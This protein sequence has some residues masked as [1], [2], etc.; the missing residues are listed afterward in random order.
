MAMSN[1]HKYLYKLD[2]FFA[3]F[4]WEH[5]VL[6]YL[7][8]RLALIEVKVHFD[9]LDCWLIHEHYFG[10]NLIQERFLFTG[11]HDH[12]LDVFQYF[13]NWFAQNFIP[14]K[15]FIIIFLNIIRFELWLN[16]YYE[17]FFFLQ[18]H[19]EVMEFPI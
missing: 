7:I 12:F 14:S 2:L 3:D 18:G 4:C 9:Q 1:F 10:F 6:I 19:S 17:Y 13:Y 11:I 15:I 5:L 8:F 16:F